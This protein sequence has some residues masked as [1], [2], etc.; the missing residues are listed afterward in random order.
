MPRKRGRKGRRRAPP[1]VNFVSLGCA[2]N[3]VDTER[4]LASLV[5]AGFLIAARPEDADAVVVNTCG[6]IAPAR[7]ESLEVLAEFA[8]LRRSGALGALVAVGC[9]VTRMGEALRAEVP[10]LD[11]ALGLDRLRE[12]PAVLAGVL[13][14]ETAQ[15]GQTA[16]AGEFDSGARLPTGP[17]GSAY[18]KISEGCDNR[19]AYCTIPDIRGP[20]RSRRADD[21]VAEA[22]G[23]AGCG[24]VELNII[25]QDVAAYGMDLGPE[26]KGALPKLLGRLCR[27]D[28]IE[29]I[30]LL[31]AHPGHVDGALVALMAAESKICPYLDLPIQHIDDM[32]LM[33]MGR[34]GDRAGEGI[35]RLVSELRGQ[36]PDI[37]IRTT[38]MVGFPGETAEAH[39]KLVEFIAEGHF[40]HLG[41][42]CYSPE[43]GTR[44]AEATPRVD[45]ETALR[46][47]EEVAGAQMAVVR[48][49]LD[50]LAGRELDVIVESRTEQ[51]GIWRARTAWD[52]PEVDSAVM[53]SGEGLVAGTIV[54][55]AVTGAEGYD[56]RAALVG[57]RG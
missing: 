37:A 57:D 14:A 31:Y 15:T 3:T 51:G 24:V 12:L 40:A 5:E 42:F 33:R 10:E 30:R 27:V 34:G 44:A 54:R 32:M 7:A 22:H 56:L 19:C 17:P 38:V 1:A 41:V 50:G 16:P 13:G 48:A 35:R 11:A 4:M 49:R 9:A 23:L 25:A 29:W 52:A 45:A 36:I 28:G 2:K 18:L 46:R 39:G 26:G 20:L 21:L 43:E 47:A 55:A 8:A 53:L 6:F